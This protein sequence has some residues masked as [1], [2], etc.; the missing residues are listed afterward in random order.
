MLIFLPVAYFYSRKKNP[1]RELGLYSQSLQTDS[2]KTL[3]LLAALVLVSVLISVTASVAGLND[4][5][6]VFEQVQKIKQSDMWLFGYLLVVRV[7]AEEIFF[8]GFLTTKIGP[9][10]S[11][12]VFGAAHAF[13]GSW[14]EVFGAMVLGFVLAKAFEKNKT[15]LPNI[16]GH[17][18]YNLLVVVTLIR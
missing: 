4:T 1:L 2:V 6:K 18:L 13:Y 11:S 8:R 10:F 5:N 12:I 9:V 17:F 7:I 14:L 15:L 16:A 3:Q